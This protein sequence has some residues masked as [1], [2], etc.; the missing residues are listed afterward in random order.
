MLAGKEIER[1]RLLETTLKQAPKAKAKNA[2]I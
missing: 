2:E 1:P